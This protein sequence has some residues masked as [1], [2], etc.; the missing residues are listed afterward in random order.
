V[1]V[2][3]CP[4]QAGIRH[5]AQ[6]RLPTRLAPA[7]EKRAYS[8]RRS[9]WPDSESISAPASSFEQFGTDPTAFS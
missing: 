3:L 2:D 5:L 7:H 9:P 6:A 8:T 1:R 4:L